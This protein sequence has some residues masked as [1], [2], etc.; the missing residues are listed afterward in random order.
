MT[1][2]FQMFI[3]QRIQ[4][5]SLFCLFILPLLY[6]AGCGG[7]VEVIEEVY[8][9]DSPRLIR[10]Y[11]KNDL[12]TPLKEI[13]YY[14]NGNKQMEGSFKNELRHGVWTYYYENGNKWSE[15][16][17]REGVYHGRTTTWHENGQKRYQGTYRNG[18]KTGYWKFWTEDGELSSKV[19]Y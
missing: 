10:V 18:E 15:N 12:E 14:P 6:L 5:L 9:D 8:D 13:F 7:T 4:K 19:K 11:D 17:F 2:F 1:N 3:Y 16:N